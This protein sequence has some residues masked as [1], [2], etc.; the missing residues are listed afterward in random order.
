MREMI[1]MILVI[2]ILA[3]VSGGLLAAVK[4]GTAAQIEAQ[5]L[6]FVQG[7][8]LNKMLAGAT[9]DPLNDRFDIDDTDFFVGKM[10]DGSNIVVF[11]TF[12]SGYGGPIGVMVGVNIATDKIFAIGVTTHTETPG[13]GSRAQTDPKFARQFAD[14]NMV[15]VFKVKADGGDVDALAGATVTSMGVSAAV[16]RAGELYEKLAPQIKDKA[17]QQT[18]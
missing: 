16:T 10:P 17:R 4:Q 11:E 14:K 18:S 13:L 7:P 3:S 8:A 6:K 15:Q 5:V 1:K 2:T 12:G 9:N